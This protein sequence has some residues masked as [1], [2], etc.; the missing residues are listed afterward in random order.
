MVFLLLLIVL[1]GHNS[2]AQKP[3]L[4]NYVILI[5]EDSFSKGFEGIKKYYWII[6]ADSINSS[7][8]MF[9][10]LLLEGFSKANFENCCKGV[11]VDPFVLTKAD[12]IF[13]MGNAYFKELESLDKLISSKRKK[14]QQ[15]VKEWT[16]KK[17]KE[18]I[19][20]YITPVRGRFCNSEFANTGQWRTGYHGRIFIPYSSF[21]VNLDFWNST[22]LSILA[23]MDFSNLKFNMVR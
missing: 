13:D 4:K 19:T 10:P 12:S 1:A 16:L 22:Q 21:Q 3:E 6:E 9:N 18:L 2:I 23:N 8:R 20:F 15:I 14:I 5:V 11:N 17:S 7:T